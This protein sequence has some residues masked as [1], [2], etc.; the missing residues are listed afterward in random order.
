MQKILTTICALAMSTTCLAQKPV[1]G[2]VDMELHDYGTE[3]HQPMLV[4]ALHHILI[5]NNSYMPIDVNYLYR[6]CVEGYKCDDVGGGVRIPA[7]TVWQGRHTTM[8]KDVKFGMAGSYK[9]TAETN[10]NNV[11]PQVNQKVAWITVR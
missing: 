8:V 9:I 3:V 10:I 5:S 7:R 4:T 2:G 6:L 11:I 1:E